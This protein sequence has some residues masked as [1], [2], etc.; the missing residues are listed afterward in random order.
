MSASCLFLLKIIA[1][2]EVSVSKK[3]SIR[4]ALYIGNKDVKRKEIS[5]EET[6]ESS[7]I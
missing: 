1:V 4:L 6:E 3:S 2:R 7:S 5:D